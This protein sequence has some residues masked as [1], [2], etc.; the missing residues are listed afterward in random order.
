MK[1]TDR[2]LSESFYTSRR[3]EILASLGAIDGD[4]TFG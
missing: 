1:L 2:P 4:V 3:G